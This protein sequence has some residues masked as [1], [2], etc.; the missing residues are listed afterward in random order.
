MRTVETR[1]G[2]A[3][4]ALIGFVTCSLAQVPTLT[5]RQLW[6]GGLF[7]RAQVPLEVEVTN[8]GGNTAGLLSAQTPLGQTVYPVELPKGSRKVIHVYMPS[9]SW[10]GSSALQLQTGNGNAQVEVELKGQGSSNS[11][12]VGVIADTPGLLASLRAVTGNKQPLWDTTCKPEDAPTRSIGYTG[13]KMLVL[14]DGSERLSDASI[15]AVQ[16][17]VLTG[18]HLVMTGG[19]SAPWLRDARWKALLPAEPGSAS[20]LPGQAV[21]QLTGAMSRE[22]LSIVR[23]S[24]RRGTQVRVESEGVPLMVDRQIGLGLVSLWT[25]DPFAD[26]IRTSPSRDT[27]F[28]NA[29]KHQTNA[30][31]YLGRDDGSKPPLPSFTEPDTSNPFETD[32]PSAGL[33]TLILLAFLIVAVP[34]NF[35]VLNKMNRRELAWLTIPVISIGFSAAIFAT[36]S[37]LYGAKMARQTQGATL[38]HDGMQEAVFVGKQD[39]FL[40]RAGRYDLGFRGVESATNINREFSMFGGPKPLGDTPELIDIGEV[41]APQ[42]EATNLTFRAFRLV[43]TV[44][45]EGRIQF[46]PKVVREKDGWRITGELRNS[47]KLTLNTPILSYLGGGAGLDSIRPGESLPVNVKLLDGDR[48]VWVGRSPPPTGSCVALVAQTDGLSIGAQVGREQGSGGNTLVYTW[49]TQ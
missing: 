21:K 9:S 31:D 26:P 7:Q 38:V 37:S 49:D 20:T 12:F 4:L 6:P 22:P 33:I 2:I 40:P 18:G 23:V 1:K 36:A 13:L 19:P 35:F 30:A 48:Q 16:R 25:F 8:Q 14:S 5:Y 44:P 29:A 46:S 24:P 39:L 41:V 32:M 28:R 34:V 42:F 15:S 11:A 3:G 47:T 27:L 43:Q 45:F 10:Y 17:Y